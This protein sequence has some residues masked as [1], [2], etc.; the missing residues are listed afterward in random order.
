MRASGPQELANAL[1]RKPQGKLDLL[2]GEAEAGYEMPRGRDVPPA[3]LPGHQDGIRQT[4]EA[5]REILDGLGDPEQES[6]VGDGLAEVLAL[7]PVFPLEG[8][9]VA[10]V[11]PTNPLPPR[12]FTWQ[13]YR[14]SRTF[15]GPG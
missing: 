9:D 11:R 6:V 5:R 7:A 12:A 3:R 8:Q 15:G 2:V 1:G 14:T 4:Q 10:R 13:I